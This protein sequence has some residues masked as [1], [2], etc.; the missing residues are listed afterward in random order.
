[1]LPQYL[2]TR[3][4]G[5]VMSITKSAEPYDIKMERKVKCYVIRGAQAMYYSRKQPKTQPLHRV[6]VPR[7]TQRSQSPRM[8]SLSICTLHVFSMMEGR[9]EEVGPQMWP[10]TTTAVDR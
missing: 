9:V 6:R 10:S 7:L 1:M 4:R 3:S 8:S 2:E 5:N